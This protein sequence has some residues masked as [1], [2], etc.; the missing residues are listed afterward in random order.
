MPAPRQTMKNS[1]SILLWLQAGG[2]QPT[3]NSGCPLRDRH[4]AKQSL[5]PA[6]VAGW[7]LQDKT[8]L[9]RVPWVQS[10]TMLQNRRASH[11]TPRG[12]RGAGGGP[13]VAGAAAFAAARCGRPMAEARSQPKKTAADARSSTNR[14][15]DERSNRPTHAWHNTFGL[16][17]RT[18]THGCP[19]RVAGKCPKQ[20][21]WFKNGEKRLAPNKKR[22]GR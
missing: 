7:R 6:L 22:Y 2:S 15:G 9:R 13:G 12:H 16:A 10:C 19:F 4:N 20:I 14:F 18:K 21:C 17:L 1:A 3:Q 11:P 8:H 5:H